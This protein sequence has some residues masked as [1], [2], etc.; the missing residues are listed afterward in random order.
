MRANVSEYWVIDRFRRL[1][2]VFTL[3]AGKVHQRVLKENQV[4]K[5]SLLPG[6][7]LPLAKLLAKADRWAEDDELIS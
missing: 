3:K 2:T 7:E 1:M 4:Y 6:F 5:T